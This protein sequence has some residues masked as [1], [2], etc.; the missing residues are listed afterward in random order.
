M[1]KLTNDELWQ[2]ESILDDGMLVLFIRDG[3]EATRHFRMEFPSKVQDRS[4]KLEEFKYK[5]LIGKEDGVK[6]R[7]VLEKENKAIL[8]E[9]NTERAD[10]MRKLEDLQRSFVEN[11]LPDLPDK[12]EDREA[13]EE[14]MTIKTEDLQKTIALVEALDISKR[15]ILSFC[16][17]ELALQ[18]YIERLTQLC[19]TQVTESDDWEPVWATW[20]LF[21]NDHNPLVQLL[22]SNSRM[23]ITSGV[24]FFASPPS[25]PNGDSDT[26][27]PQKD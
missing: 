16:A 4:A 7:R 13:F 15:E 23:F 6:S 3:E 14:Q 9:I 19:W 8:R 21:E 12:E 1:R 25:P 11:E 17:E 18:H 24:P 22:T 20:E 10:L 5:S 2:L 26:S 27:M